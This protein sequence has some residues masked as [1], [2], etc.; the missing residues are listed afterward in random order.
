MTTSASKGPPRGVRG[1]RRKGYLAHQREVREDVCADR[2]HH[3]V[4]ER[5]HLEAQLGVLGDG[6]DDP[7]R[8]M[9]GSAPQ[10]DEIPH[11]R[12]VLHEAET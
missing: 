8:G 10:G 12:L 4:Q 9:G 5:E 3:P 6:D 7:E 1:V 2:L 11:P